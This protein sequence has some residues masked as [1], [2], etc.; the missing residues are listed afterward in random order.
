LLAQAIYHRDGRCA[1]F[2]Y[3]PRHNHLSQI[4]HLNATGIEDQVL[5]DR[6]AE[7]VRVYTTPAVPAF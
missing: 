1:N 6:L 7:F 2:Q 4:S 5:S 3:L